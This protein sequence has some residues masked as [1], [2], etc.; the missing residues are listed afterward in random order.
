MYRL[1]IRRFKCTKC[2][3]CE[4]DDAL[5]GFTGDHYGTILISDNYY[6]KPEVRRKLAKAIDACPVEAIVLD[7]I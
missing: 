7:A 5:P 1:S 4:A 2:L 3:K 6:E